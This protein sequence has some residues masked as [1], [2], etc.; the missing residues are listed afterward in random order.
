MSRRVHF[1]ERRVDEIFVDL[2]QCH[3]PGVAVGVAVRGV[4][5]Y[6]KGFGLANVELPVALSCRM[7]MRLFSVSKQF[8]CLAYLLLCEEGRASLD[9]P[10]GKYLPE[11]H[12]AARAVTARQ[13]MG[14]ISGLRDSHDITWVFS[15]TAASV[16]SADLLYFYRAFDDANCPPGTSWIYNNGGFLLLTFMVERITGQTLE[17]VLRSRIFEPIGMQDTLLRRTQTDF[18][19]NSAT[20]HMVWPDGRFDR[21]YLGGERGG[22]GGIVSTVDDMLRWLAHMESPIVGNEATWVA[23]RTPQVLANGQSTGY[24]L[25]LFTGRHRGLDTVFHSGG[26]LGGNAFMLKVASAA[27]DIIVLANRYDVDSAALAHR[28]IDACVPGLPAAAS[29][30][31]SSMHVGV[32]RSPATG[33]VVQLFSKEGQQRAWVDNYDLPMEADLDGV[34]HPTQSFKYLRQSITPFGG[35]GKLESVRFEDFGNRDVLVRVFPDNVLQPNALFGRYRS[36]STGTDAQFYPSDDGLHLCTRGRFGS[37]TFA[38]ESLGG[39]AWRAT[40][41]LPWMGGIVSFNKDDRM[42]RFTTARTWGLPFDR[43]E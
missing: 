14:N 8:A 29:A 17:E 21:S 7:R 38:L 22:E 26:G 12:A 5:L 6:R 15:G 23:M 24:G 25:G 43:V 33:R 13:L 16:L 31:P 36:E 2:D 35:G 11:V 42:F 34:L 1:D 37:A 9:D 28:I 19:P 3:L 10:I 30:A 39:G 41:R 32:F 20:M 18:V 27:L 40:S 4:P